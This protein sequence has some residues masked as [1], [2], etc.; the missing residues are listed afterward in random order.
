MSGAGND[1]VVVDN[2][3]GIITD[4]STFARFVCRRRHNIGADGL[5]LLENSSK[6][7][8]LM[9]YYNADGSNAGMCGNGGRC[10]SKFAFDIGAV[11][12]NYFTFEAF[13]HIY[14]AERLESNIYELVMKNP[15]APIHGQNIV[16]PGETIIGNYINTGTDHS[17]IFL[18]D[19]PHIGTMETVSVA[20]IGKMVRYHT[21]YAPGGTNVNFVLRTG[22][23][24]ITIRTYERGV[25]EETLACG[26]GSVAS[27]L[28]SSH[29]YQMESPIDVI[30]KSGEILTISFEKKNE[31][32]TGVRLKGKAETTFNGVVEISQ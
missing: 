29:K 32:F 8:F 23:N 21:I 26:T 22:A 4:A 17:V 12:T 6:A 31:S 18:D 13:G 24:Q 16:I 27:A 3:A 7:D 2:R 9:K 10:L 5:L 30:V 11:Q 14:R 28:L 1:F 15:S 25:E 19:N 20:G